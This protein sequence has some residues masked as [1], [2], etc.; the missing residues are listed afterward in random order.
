MSY[1][2][3]IWVR[4]MAWE[5]I[6]LFATK[7]TCANLTPRSGPEGWYKPLD[8]TYESGFSIELHTSNG[9]HPPVYLMGNV[10]PS[11][12]GRAG[13]R[14]LLPL[15]ICFNDMVLGHRAFNFFVIN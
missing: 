8:M 11:P 6:F 14:S 13:K 7:F 5:K 1:K 4:F 15:P 9:V 2:L 12:S 3:G 10:S